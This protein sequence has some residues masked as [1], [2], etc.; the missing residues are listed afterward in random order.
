M[1]AELSWL[2]GRPIAHRGLHSGDGRYPENSM[3]AFARAIDRSYG[4]ELDVRLLGDGNPVVFHDDNTA[5]MTGEVHELS[6]LQRDHLRDLRLLGSGQGAPLLAEVLEMAQ[7]RTPIL[8]EIK[9]DG[10]PGMLEESILSL[11]NTYQGPLA[12]QSFNPRSLRWFR[13]NAQPIPRG[14]IIGRT[15]HSGGFRKQLLFS[16]SCCPAFV[17]YRIGDLPNWAAARQKGQ[18]LPILGW[19][20]K[21]L[22]E[23]KRALKWCDNV[24][25]EGFEP[26]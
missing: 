5:R 21:S 6:S 4:I 23:Y 1:D 22:G 17:N 20:A 10:E 16:R 19:T 8:L 14:L 13:I 9:N 25:F 3:A 18:G 24:V 2:K 7:G 26:G 12:V 11:L 15:P